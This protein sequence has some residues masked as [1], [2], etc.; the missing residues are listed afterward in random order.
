MFVFYLFLLSSG[1]AIL[2]CHIAIYCV[3][4]TLSLCQIT[5]Q[6]LISTSTMNVFAIVLVGPYIFFSCM[7]Y[8]KLSLLNQ[9]IYWSLLVKQW[10]AKLKTVIFHF[11][12]HLH[13][14]EMTLE[15][16]NNDQNERCPETK[17]NL[18]M[19]EIILCPSTLPL[20]YNLF[21]TTVLPFFLLS[22][23][24]DSSSTSLLFVSLLLSSVQFAL[25]FCSCPFLFSYL[26]LYSD[27]SLL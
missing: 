16:T 6:A 26:F 11:H 19:F 27:I 10:I 18:F 13:I 3:W 2:L 15:D 9:F 8:Q 25:F 4:F 22:I 23:L 17:F 5:I 24:S 14:H 12:V 20:I 21:I 7:K 1:N